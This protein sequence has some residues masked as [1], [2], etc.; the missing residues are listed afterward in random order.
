MLFGLSLGPLWLTA[1]R[2]NPPPSL[3]SP[4]LTGCLKTPRV[5]RE[6]L[7]NA[8]VHRTSSSSSGRGQTFQLKEVPTSTTNADRHLKPV[9]DKP[10]SVLSTFV[11]NI[12]YA[13]G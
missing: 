13:I 12:F 10:D 8:V 5:F 9:V 4:L 11:H 7:G 3:A 2:R 6:F 1:S